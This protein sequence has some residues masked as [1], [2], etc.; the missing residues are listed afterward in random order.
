MV[1]RITLGGGCFWCLEAIFS[2]VN[3]IIKVLPGYSGGHLKNPTYEQVCTD[4][5]GHAEVVDILFDNSV[6]SLEDIL[7]IFFFI[8]NCSLKSRIYDTGIQRAKGEQFKSP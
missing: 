5:T 8:K 3:W 6:I 7:E 1:E 4:T 2:N